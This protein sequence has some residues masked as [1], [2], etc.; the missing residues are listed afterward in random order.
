MYSAHS[1]LSDGDILELT[2]NMYNILSIPNVLLAL[3]QTEYTFER[4]WTTDGGGGGGDG[5]G[6][7][8]M[9]VHPTVEVRVSWS[10]KVSLCIKITS[11]YYQTF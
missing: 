5:D 7:S 6:F 1:F 8:W 10:C 11:A 2:D 9:V 3:K 4:R